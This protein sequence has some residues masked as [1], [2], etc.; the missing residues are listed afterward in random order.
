[1]SVVIC[2]IIF[3][4]SQYTLLVQDKF[5]TLGINGVFGLRPLSITVKNIM[6]QKPDLYPS[7]G[8][9]VG[10]IHSVGTVRKS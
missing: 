7:S 2:Y 6:F 1:M 8:E 4:C 3:C 10:D 5:L 9:K